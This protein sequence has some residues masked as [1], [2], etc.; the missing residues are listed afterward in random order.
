MGIHVFELPERV[1]YS[2]KSTP[3]E[4]RFEWVN[5]L[6]LLSIIM[7]IALISDDF[8]IIIIILVPLSSSRNLC[9]NLKYLWHTSELEVSVCNNIMCCVLMS[10][11][12]HLTLPM[13]R[14]L[15]F[16][17]QGQKDF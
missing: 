12:I 11:S 5:P 17:A 6:A 9:L 16:K 8:I 14:L 2:V 1:N 4:P 10:V 13:L 15:S 3:C 7:Q